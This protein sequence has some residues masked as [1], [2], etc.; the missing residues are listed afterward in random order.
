M[1]TIGFVRFLRGFVRHCLHN[2]SCYRPEDF[3]GIRYW[4]AG[5]WQGELPGYQR[6]AFLACFS[7]GPSAKILTLSPTNSARGSKGTGCSCSTEQSEE[8]LKIL[9]ILLL[10]VQWGLP[11]PAV[12][13]EGTLSGT[14]PQVCCGFGFFCQSS[15]GPCISSSSK[16]KAITYRLIFKTWAE[17]NHLCVLSS[18]CSGRACD[19]TLRESPCDWNSTPQSP[20]LTSGCARNMPRPDAALP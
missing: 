2:R 14:T 3:L 16:L 19:G 15:Q 18:C 6:V 7:Q 1:K 20:P 11:E 13:R 12:L 9:H 17:Q 10:G 8:V 4:E 5:E